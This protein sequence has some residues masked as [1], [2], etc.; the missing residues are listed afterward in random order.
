MSKLVADTRLML[1]EERGGGVANMEHGSCSGEKQK[2]EMN[3]W[4]QG[5]GSAMEGALWTP[6]GTEQGKVIKPRI[7]QDSVRASIRQAAREWFLGI[8]SVLGFRA[9]EA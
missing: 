2:P 4:E 7:S 1:P 8:Y 6:L 5:T 9:E 3:D